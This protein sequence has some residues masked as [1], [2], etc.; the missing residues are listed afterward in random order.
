MLGTLI[1]SRHAEFDLTNTRIA[2]SK[3]A[4]CSRSCRQATSIGRT[5]SATSE[6][7]SSRA[8][9]FRSKGNPRIVPGRRPNVLSTP[10]MWFDRYFRQRRPAAILRSPGGRRRQDRATPGGDRE[11]LG[12]RYLVLRAFTGFPAGLGLRRAHNELA[13][14]DD[15]HHRAA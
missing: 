2:L 14:R 13:S 4:I 7:L 9:T 6:R 12:D 11:R 1:S 8:S 5:I 10:R 15:D 3:T